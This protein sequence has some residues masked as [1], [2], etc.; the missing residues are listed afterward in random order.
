MLR[1]RGRWSSVSSQARA[2]ARP[3]A[4]NAGS[5]TARNAL[6]RHGDF[7]RLWSAQTVSDFGAR[8][9]REGLPMMAIMALA[10]TAPQLGV[11]AALASGSALLVGLTVGDFVDHTLR[12]PILIAMDL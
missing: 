8:I 6:W 9:T 4:L 11:L 12:R 3:P 5:S 1:T 2:V 10:A 7:L